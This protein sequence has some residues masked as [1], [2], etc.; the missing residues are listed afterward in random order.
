[1]FLCATVPLSEHC[2]QGC[3]SSQSKTNPSILE[4]T[5]EQE[6]EAL[7]QSTSAVPAS[8]EEDEEE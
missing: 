2:S 4:T 1:M 3:P 8:L 7:D 6:N 5:S